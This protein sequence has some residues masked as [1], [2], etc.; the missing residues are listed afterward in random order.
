VSTVE[1][2]QHLAGQGVEL[3][4]EAERLRFRAPKGSFAPEQRAAVGARRAEVVAELRRQAGEQEKRCPL[5]FSQRSLWFLHQQ[6]PDSTAYHVAMSMR[7]RSAVQPDA[8]RQAVQA[9][10]DRHAIL[11]TTY[12][13]A[14]SGPCQR[15]AGTGVAAFEA[16][17]RPGVSEDD[18]RKEVE[19]DYRRPFDLANGPVLRVSLYTRAPADHVLLLTV[20]H[21]AADG[22]SLLI[23]FQEFTRLYEEFSGGAAAVLERPAVQY[24]DYSAWQEQLLAGPEGERLWAYWRKELAGPRSPVALPADRQRP[25]IQSFHGASFGFELPAELTARVKTLAREQGTTPFVVLLASFHAFLYRLTDREDIIVGTPTFARSKAE[26]VSVV[27]DFVNPVA[28]RAR[29]AAGM[30]RRALIAQLRETVH[31]ALDAQEFPLPLVVERLHPER[32]ASRTPLFDTFFILQRF[33]QFRELEDLLIGGESEQLVARGP[34]RLAAYP[35]HQQEGQFDLALQMAERAGV[36]YGVF[37]YSTDMF[38]AATMARWAADYLALVAA[39]VAEP[40]ASLDTLPKPAGPT[41]RAGDGPALLASLEKRDIRLSL[42]G[43]R[44]KVNAPKGALDAAAKALLTERKAELLEALRARDAAAN[45]AVRRLPRGCALP[46]SSAQQRLWFLDRM[47]PGRPEY[48]LGLGVRFR[49]PLDE[50]SMRRAV[51]ALVAR[52]ESLHMRLIEAGGS[53]VTHILSEV[54]AP[55]EVVDLAPLA[56]EARETEALRLLG[57]CLRQPFDLAQGP[58]C[59]FQLTRL[60][61]QEHLLTICMHHAASDG[62][63]LVIAVEEIFRL[64]EAFAAGRAPV[65]AEL[66][67]QYADYAAWEREQLHSGRMTQHLTFWKQQLAGAPVVLEMPLDRPRPAAQSFRGARMRRELDGELL[68][69]LKQF[70]RQQG[71]TLFMTLVAVWQVLLHRYSGQDEI[72]VGSPVANR[73]LPVFEGLIGCIVNNVVLR[74]NLAGN[75]TFSEYLARVK[76]TTL[77]AFEHC[78]L[79]FDV[80]VEGVNPQRTASHA[81]LFQVLF[82]FL[83]FPTNTTP[84]AGLTAEMVESDTRASRFDLTIE[85]LERD[86]RLSGLYE[87]ATDLFDEATIDRLHSHFETLLRAVAADPSRSIRDLPLL[88]REDERLLMEKW[89]DTVVEHDRGRCVHQLLEAVARAQPDAVA[90]IGGEETLTYAQLEQRANQLAHL[91]RNRGIEP[92]ALVGVCLDRTVDMPIALAAVLKAGAAYV[93]LDPAHPADRL[94][95]T[96]QDA[97]VAC[98]ITLTRFA[99]QVAD[100]GAPLLA[101]D[102]LHAELAKQ[103]STAPTVAVKPEDLCYVIYT[104]GSTG[105]PKGVQVEH[106]NVVSFLEAMRREP[107]LDSHDVLLA[108]TTLSFDIAGLEMWLPLTVGARIVVASRTDVLDGQRLAELMETHNVSLLQATPATWRLLLETGWAGRQN[109]KALCGGEALQRDLAISLVDRVGELWNVYGPTE[110]TIW[111]TVNRVLDPHMAIPIGH[112]IA[113]TRV[114][115]L[116]PSGQPAPVGVAGE[117]CIAGEGIAR[118]YRNRP[119]LTAEKFATIAL[120]QNRSER[121]YRT[122]DMARFRADG[123]LEFL[124][125]RDTQVKVRGYRIEL[126]EIEAVLATHAGIKECVVVVREDTPGDQRLVGY[127]VA[128][129]GTQFDAESARTTLRGRLPEYMLPNLFVTL[130]MLPLTPNGKIDRKALPKPHAAVAADETGAAD[131]V[132]MTSPQRRVAGIWRD[133]LRVGRIG[134][135]DNFFDLGGHSLLL[136]KLQSAL[137]REFSSDIALVDLFQRTTVAAQAER[138]SSTATASDALKRAQARAVKQ[139]NG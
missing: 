106:R 133:V 81:P 63:S 74:G 4:F 128:V 76:Q 110:T 41:V 28:L 42:E 111:S 138:M 108:V 29:L 123:Q 124:G 20:H 99:E 47:D 98:V 16:H 25:D 3:W 127:V 10:V 82:T 73:S 64:Y 33:D 103:P 92:G 32:D 96:L 88:T 139:V 122:G 101:L 60:T 24:A 125:R 91:L 80:L 51:D 61:S 83:S 11:R 113:N 105:R 72:M 53:P 15:I 89:N 34:L 55:F 84:P 50:R 58:L 68:Q 67:V 115:V 93:P 17:E 121:V 46:V 19:A 12:E 6:A 2:L 78:E 49:G 30:V 31:G 102:E 13:F 39:F 97:G 136:V 44:L 59:R 37:K 100:A 23:L 14:D 9:L 18:L 86:G 21:I 75:P 87:Y 131:D 66:P 77:D 117:L 137:K 57:Q 22:W 70:S 132:L 116:E 40:E 129:G 69:Q 112:P 65:L 36:L 5:S 62:W 94:S 1:L 90:V 85:L 95:Y 48:N 8:L 114:Y 52:H 109:L 38:E 126:G 119:E 56:P 27:G 79:P 107:G 45:G 7:I 43:E 104:S 54:D 135:Y 120:P 35:L 26:F 130:S 134:L 118:G 71:A